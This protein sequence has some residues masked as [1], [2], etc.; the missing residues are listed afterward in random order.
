[1]NHWT[2]EIRDASQSPMIVGMMSS[3]WIAAAA[4]AA[5]RRQPAKERRS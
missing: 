1:M 4:A 5:A 3:Q 2:L